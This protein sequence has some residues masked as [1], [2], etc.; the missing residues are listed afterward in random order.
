MLHFCSILLQIGDNRQLHQILRL[1]KSIISTRTKNIQTLRILPSG[2]IVF[3][4]INQS[5]CIEI[6][7]GSRECL[8]WIT[9]LTK[10]NLDALQSF[11]IDGN[12]LVPKLFCAGSQWP[13]MISFSKN[14]DKN[15][16]KLSI[17]LKIY[18]LACESISKFGLSI[19]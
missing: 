13:F 9:I 18:I 2:D 12:L 6:L 10:R 1:E 19:L 11:F 8:V 14:T 7:G 15:L 4:L 16:L 5:D 17:Y 3:A